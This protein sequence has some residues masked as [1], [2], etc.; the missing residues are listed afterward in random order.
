MQDEAVALPAVFIDDGPGTGCGVVDDVLLKPLFGPTSDMVLG[1]SL[2]ELEGCAGGAFHVDRAH[3]V[4]HQVE[5]SLEHPG[6]TDATVPVLANH[7]QPAGVGREE[8]LV[9]IEEGR[10]PGGVGKASF[11]VGL[12]VHRFSSSLCR[13]YDTGLHGDGPIFA[14]LPP[15]ACACY[16]TCS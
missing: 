15:R 13:P 12:S 8:R 11:Q 14:H 6:D 9:Q 10:H 1:E 5:G 16:S 3:P 4:E 2:D 7:P